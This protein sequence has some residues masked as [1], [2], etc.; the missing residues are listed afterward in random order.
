MSEGSETGRKHPGEQKAFPRMVY[1]EEVRPKLGQ[2][3]PLPPFWGVC[4]G[5]RMESSERPSLSSLI[6]CCQRQP[7]LSAAQEQMWPHLRN[8]L[9][10]NCLFPGYQSFVLPISKSMLARLLYQQDCCLS[11]GTQEANPAHCF[12]LQKRQSSAR[13]DSVPCFHT[14][15]EEANL[16]V[17]NTHVA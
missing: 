3:F 16:L 1:K 7:G 17:L 10:I 4:F 5:K 14:V 2:V 11:P 8:V 13:C 9:L 15:T 12:L 6:F